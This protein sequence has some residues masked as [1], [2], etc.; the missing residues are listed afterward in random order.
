MTGWKRQVCAPK[1][2]SR[3]VD[4][5]QR[6]SVA[7]ACKVRDGT[8]ITSAQA[9][10]G[11]TLHSV[12]KQESRPSP[13]AFSTTHKNTLGENLSLHYSKQSLWDALWRRISSIHITNRPYPSWT[14]VCHVPCKDK[15]CYHGRKCSH[16]RLWIKFVPQPTL[17]TNPCRLTASLYGG[18]EMPLT[19]CWIWTAVLIEAD[20]W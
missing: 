7:R 18:Q 14:S 11:Y 16:F 19:A 5:R 20:S 17:C 4:E 12:S 9:T 8:R 6:V 1:T 10:C 15:R 3:W 2:M 13:F